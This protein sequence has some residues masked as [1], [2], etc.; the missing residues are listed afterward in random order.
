MCDARVASEGLADRVAEAS[1][2][3][4]REVW[5]H[6][7]SDAPVSAVMAGAQAAKRRGAPG[8][9][10]VGGGSALDTGKAAALVARHGGD[11]A[12]WDGAGKVGSPGL[13]LVAIPTTAGTGSEVS[14]IAVL[15]D[16]ERSRKLVIVDR[17]V[18]PAV[19][20]LDPRLTLKLPPLL[21][22]ATGIDAL[23]HAIEGVV[24]RYHQPIC[25]AL[26]L[27]CVRLLRAAPPAPRG[28]RASRI[29]T[30]AEQILLAAS[31]AGQLVSLTFSGVAHAVA[32]ALGLGWGV[33][34]GTANAVTLP[35]SIRF[36][37]ADPASAAMYARCAAA[38]GLP[39]SPSDEA[40]ALALADAT[41]RF[42]ADLGLPTHLG[43]LGLTAGD[44]PRL[45]E[46]AFADPSHAP[47]P[48]QGGERGRPGE[49]AGDACSEEVALLDRSEDSRS[50]PRLRGARWEVLMTP[51][52]KRTARFGSWQCAHTEKA[53]AP[54]F[55]KLVRN[56]PVDES[57]RI[58]RIASERCAISER[59]PHARVSERHDREERRRACLPR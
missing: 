40:A 48:P 13:P 49:S 42:T 50:A 23:A 59:T 37:A 12:R 33:H 38:F 55:G 15:K 10:A 43:A 25:D 34:H 7:E 2:G 27:E 30:P 9:V 3:R 41:A 17:A 47:Q 4:V 31:M 22:A 19:A 16:G 20:I 36:N 57:V 52:T 54:R 58:D 24:S 45:A 44:L 11:P 29:S 46:L 14:S 6:V 32:H 53:H 39:P 5:A 26:G 8:H 56:K 1:A 18:Y 28:L 51:A 21:T 35:W